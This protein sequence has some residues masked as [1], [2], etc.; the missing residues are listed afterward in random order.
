MNISVGT[1][2]DESEEN[3]LENLGVVLVQQSYQESKSYIDEAVSKMSNALSDIH[4][5]ELEDIE[6]ISSPLVTQ[7]QSVFL[8]PKSAPPT[9]LNIHFICE[10][11]S[12]LLFRTI[13]WTKQLPIFQNLK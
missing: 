8:F 10:A 5:D 12:R 9:Y 7:E 4:E 3:K 2:Y 11:A 1:D 6:E 13:D